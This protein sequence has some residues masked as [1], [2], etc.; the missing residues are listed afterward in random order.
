MQ[1]ILPEN[2]QRHSAAAAAWAPWVWRAAA[3]VLANGP[4]AI[5]LHQ[6]DAD[7]VRAILMAAIELVREQARRGPRPRKRAA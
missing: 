6:R 1:D 7:E 3:V 5:A 4:E 2:P